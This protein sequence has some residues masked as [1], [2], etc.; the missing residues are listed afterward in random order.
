MFLIET[1]KHQILWFI[2]QVLYYWIPRKKTKLVRRS[3]TLWE[4]RKNFPMFWMNAFYE[5]MLHIFVYGESGHECNRTMEMMFK[6]SPVQSL[7]VLS[8]H[9]EYSAHENELSA[10]FSQMFAGHLSTH[11]ENWKFLFSPVMFHLSH[12]SFREA[13]AE[14]SD[15]ENERQNKEK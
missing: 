9:A 14:M 4:Q 3:K 12:C 8:C 1:W 2:L 7:R 13:G 11:W 6:P 5:Q 10:L 15:T